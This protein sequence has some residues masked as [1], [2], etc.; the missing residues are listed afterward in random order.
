M[1]QLFFDDV[2]VINCTPPLIPDSGLNCGEFVV[3]YWRCCTGESL[4]MCMQV[5]KS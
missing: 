5:V 1:L 2:C 3:L 4:L